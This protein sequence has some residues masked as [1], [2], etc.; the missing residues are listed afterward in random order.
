[1]IAAQAGRFDEAAELIGQ[2]I[3]I[4][5][6]EAVYYRNLVNALRAARKL[7][8][9]IEPCRQFLRLQP[10]T[11]EMHNQLG[12]LLHATGQHA[13]AADA[14]RDAIRLRSGYGEAWNN[15]GMSLGAAGQF[16]QAIGAYRHSIALQ[17]MPQTWNNLANALKA[18]GQR[19][20]A[21]DAY[22]IAVK[23]MPASAEMWNNLGTTLRET[24]QLDE[25]VQALGRAVALSPGLASAHWNFALALLQQGD[26]PRGFAEYEWRWKWPGFRSRRPDYVQPQWRGEE[27]AGKTILLHLEQG[28]GDAIQFIRYAAP[29]ADR[30]ATVILHCPPE[31]ARLMESVR[32]VARIISTEEQCGFDVHSPL[33]SLPH[34]LGTTLETIPAG[35]PYIHADQELARSWR[36]RLS[37][38]P[39]SSAATP[40]RNVGLVWAGSPDHVL[41]D[42][43][44]IPLARLAA[45]SSVP[46]IIFHS[47]QKGDRAAEAISPP[48]GMKLVRHDANLN[49]F[50]DTAA[51]ISQLDLV[52]A[53]DTAVAH[54][55]GAMG[56]NVWV[57][58][59]FAPDWRW[60]SGREDS[61]WYPTMRLFRQETEGDWAG[62]ADRVAEALVRSSIGQGKR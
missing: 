36:E 42:R 43:R 3:E 52:I 2:A 62:V 34:A 8:A 4:R 23:L 58:I 54:L 61:P 11:P 5:P 9:A 57:L 17:P 15:L 35:V 53:V 51:L 31:L 48:P 59:P 21:I 12:S 30:G 40:G 7:H 49:D 10:L 26:L 27:I 22:R 38:G 45:L 28:R 46:D 24:G 25:S 18:K 33:M 39:V 1:M 16:D 13:S 32:G 20:E 19:Q 14:F 44:S 29:I 55:A 56:K 47:L 37:H 60:M 50:A 6:A 41:D